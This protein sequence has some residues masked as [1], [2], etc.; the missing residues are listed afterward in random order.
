MKDSRLSAAFETDNWRSMRNREK[1]FVSYS[2]RDKQWLNDFQTFVKPLIRSGTLDI[3]SD[4]QIAPSDAWRTEISDS[5]NHACIAVML[6]TPSFLA[7]DFIANVEL[8]LVVEAHK[9]GRIHVFWIP[10]STSLYQETAL[11]EIQSAHP[12]AEPLDD[13]TP[14]SRN[15]AW[16]AICE[17]IKSVI[18]TP[19]VPS[20]PTGPKQDSVPRTRNK[21]S[22]VKETTRHASVEVLSSTT[23]STER[24]ILF[25]V[26]AVQMDFIS[27]Q[28]FADVCAAWGMNKQRGMP[29][30]LKDNN[31]LDENDSEQLE[32]FLDRKL[33]KHGDNLRQTL[34]A[35]TDSTLREVIR[36][37]RDS[38]L[39]DSIDDL[40]AETQTEAG[41]KIAAKTVLSDHGD[42][43]LE[44]GRRERYEWLDIQNSDGALGEVW[45]GR[46]VDLN[47]YVALKAIK[48]D[49]AAHP[50][51]VKRFLAEAQITGQLEHPNIVPV[52]DLSKRTDDGQPFY[53]MR[54]LRGGTL[55]QAIEEL[56][57]AAENGQVD[58][59]G[60]R[61]LL[62]HLIGVCQA[63]AYAHARGVMHRDMKPENILLGPF[64]EVQVIDW[65][66]ATAFP[67][68]KERTPTGE[69]GENPLFHQPENLT[70]FAPILQPVSQETYREGQPV[71]TPGYMS[72]EQASGDNSH[73]DW[74]SD[75]Y[76]LGATLF[77]ILTG[78]P[79][80]RAN[81][82]EALLQQIIDGPTPLA[83][84]IF[85]AVPAGLE[86]IC[87]KAM[88][89]DPTQ[90]YASA[91]EL[92]DA[93]QNWLDDEPL[94]AYR[95]AVDHLGQLAR[96]H[97]D[98]RSYREGLAR[99]QINLALVLR[100]MKRLAE[101]ET[102]LRTAIGEYKKLVTTN[103]Q[104]LRYRADL[105]ACRMHLRGTLKELGRHGDAE[106]VKRETLQDYKALQEIRPRDAQQRAEKASMLTLLGH[107]PEAV[108]RQIGDSSLPSSEDNEPPSSA[109]PP[110]PEGDDGPKLPPTGR[111]AEP[112]P[113]PLK[114]NSIDLERMIQQVSGSSS[115]A[116]ISEEP[117]QLSQQEQSRSGIQSEDVISTGHTTELPEAVSRANFVTLPVE[118]WEES[119]TTA[120]GQPVTGP[121]YRI[122]M[123]LASG[124]LGQVYNAYDESLHR[125]VAIKELHE[126]YAGNQSRFLKEAEITARLEH[127]GIPPVYSLGQYPDGRLFYAMRLIR[128]ET[129]GES[130]RSIEAHRDTQWS[131]HQGAQVRELVSRLVSVCETLAYAHSRGVIHRDVKPTNIM[132]GQYGQTLLVDWGLAKVGGASCDSQ[133]DEES[134]ESLAI[135]TENVEQTMHGRVLGTPVFMAPELFHGA[136]HANA[137]SDVYALGAT[138]YQVICGHSPFEGPAMEIFALKRGPHTFRY[139]RQVDPDIPRGLEAICLKAMAYRSQDRY[140]SATELADD[141]ERWLVGETPAAYN[142]STLR[143][144]VRRF[145]G[146]LA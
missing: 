62:S 102:L 114:T 93:I 31:W 48:G 136:E 63:V 67:N 118:E 115:L 58:M 88:E 131:K 89:K 19:E 7:S 16:A 41:K 3:W 21:I 34:S 123:M 78:K 38:E 52:Y 20:V 144:V 107:E 130:I 15:R 76:N 91:S 54:L 99:Y 22:P 64:G 142:E 90:R 116:P 71:G 113:D 97:P 1:I 109:P 117:S 50:V 43:L 133:D 8:P 51:A 57:A 49:R 145:R 72:P 44:V 17:R 112:T 79:P 46:D 45:M 120:F 27:P 14:A 47:R 53:A 77:E 105:A 5:L 101:A 60:R 85:P 98:E 37:S 33:K 143:K 106:Q 121:R 9:H 110:V 124:G 129:L 141:L 139:P 86:A 18:A 36:R 128:G 13:M 122:Q 24:Q 111:A 12:V 74:R 83:T 42:S 66:F 140:Q 30:I 75:I 59:V 11:G 137:S 95:A 4:E 35:A 40:S 80:H 108:R 29:R 96:K 82:V 23:E 135:H 125:E 100:G 39:R 70:D 10:V 61:R 134:S 55:R 69:T 84:E 92:A 26:L 103:P 127:P 32:Q 28:Q 25:C 87:A 94:S 68:A 6:V 119:K 132:L 126:R 65:G 104:V 2:H 73:A 146:R 81:S 138:L 56:H